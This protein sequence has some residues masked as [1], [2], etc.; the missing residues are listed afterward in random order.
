M[1]TW[2]NSQFPPHYYSLMRPQSLW[3]L[4]MIRFFDLVP[5]SLL[6]IYQTTRC[7]SPE[8][9]ENANLHCPHGYCVK[10]HTQNA[11]RI[12]RVLRTRK[13]AFQCQFHHLKSLQLCF[14]EEEVGSLNQFRGKSCL[15]MICW[16]SMPVMWWCH[17]GTPNEICSDTV[18]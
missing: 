18:T 16:S 5:F 17:Q 3:R 14:M 11:A 13:L 12:H 7:H 1:W 8:D 2:K 10:F 4:Q 6:P 15:R 9:P